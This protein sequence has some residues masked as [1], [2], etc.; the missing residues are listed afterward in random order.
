MGRGT[1]GT[2]SGERSWRGP[3]DLRKRLEKL[4]ERGDLL[5]R[6]FRNDPAPLSLPLAPP[7]SRELLERFGEVRSW[8][9]ALEESAAREGYRLVTRSLN[10]RVLGENRLPVAAEFPGTREALRLLGREEQGEAWLLLARRTVRDF[11]MLEEWILARP[12]T[13][14]EALSEWER[15]LAVLDH[16]RR[17][18]RPNR[19]LRQL[20]IPGVDTKFVESRKVLLGTLLDLVLPEGAVDPSHTGIRGFEPRYGLLEKPVLVRFRILDPA[21]SVGGFSDL[22][23]PAEE[24][25]RTPLPVSRVYV[26]ENE[27]NGLAFPEREDSLVI[28]GLG[29]AVE[30]LF[31]ARWL[32]TAEMIYWG[33]I[34]T[35][36]FAILARLRGCFPSLRSLLMDR[37]TF[38][39]H[40]SLWVEEP[41]PFGGD[42]P[43]LLVPEREVFD[44]LRGEVRHGKGLRL[45]QERI[46]YGEVLEALASAEMCR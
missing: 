11:P 3:S 45:E 14:F 10:H 5:R 34:D 20:D 19:Y 9:R 8:A 35:H 39:R 44:L 17:Q 6:L 16:F 4:W 36:G 33:D 21:R 38:L 42:L 1:S 29:Y 27:I 2:G 43:Q 12:L 31:G 13:L 15:V 25:A 41:Q 18:P 26:V 22:T 37:E 7:G 40:R 30:R 46:P 32:R 28:F 23:V 24:F